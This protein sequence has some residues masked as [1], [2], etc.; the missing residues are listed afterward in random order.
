MNLTTCWFHLPKEKV[1][2][3]AAPKCGTSAL[4]RAV[5]QHVLKGKQAHH[6]D[7]VNWKLRAEGLVSRADKVP[8][9]YRLYQ[10]VRY[11]ISRF[12]SLWRQQWRE[13][14]WQPE[15]LVKK[16][17]A[18]PMAD[19]HWIRQVDYQ[20]G[21]DV[22]PVAQEWAI[23]FLT[24]LGVGWYPDKPHLRNAT[25]G[26]VPPYNKAPLYDHYEADFDLWE[27]ALQWTGEL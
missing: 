24:A 20:E 8:E 4:A 19:M 17:L 15:G 16:I 2:I 22:T 5:H 18:G 27:R 21:R 1:A 23:E 3:L 10:I 14:G 12:E 9:D 7:K 26:E 13:K 6:P 11:P 25:S